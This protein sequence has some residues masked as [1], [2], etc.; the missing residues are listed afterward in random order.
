[1]KFWVLGKFA[2]SLSNMVAG[3]YTFKDVRCIC[4]GEKNRTI[5]GKNVVYGRWNALGNIVCTVP[6]PL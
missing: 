4:D 2:W 5:V 3:H 6:S 1:M